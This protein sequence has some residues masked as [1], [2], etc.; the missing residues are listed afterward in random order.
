MTENIRSIALG[1]VWLACSTLRG[2]DLAETLSSIAAGGGAPE[3]VSKAL[4][5]WLDEAGFDRLREALDAT[6]EAKQRSAP[7]WLSVACVE[8]HLQRDKQALAAWKKACD[9]P[10][11]VTALMQLGLA[12]A[13]ARQRQFDEAG[14]ALE[15]MDAAKADAHSVKEA[16][17]L[18]HSMAYDR[19][20]RADQLTLPQRLAE[21]RPDDADL[22]LLLA[23]M[24]VERGS[25]PEAIR[26]T[27]EALSLAQEAPAKRAWLLVVI[28]SESR[29]GKYLEA[30]QDA[31]QGL[32]E[33]APNSED[34][35]Q[36]LERLTQALQQERRNPSKSVMPKEEEVAQQFKD[37]P[38]VVRRMAVSLRAAG[39]TPAAHEVLDLLKEE[40]VAK[41]L[42]SDWQE[43]DG[44]EPQPLVRATIAKMSKVEIAG[45]TAAAPAWQAEVKILDS[46]AR[47][48][49][50]LE[51]WKAD[52]RDQAAAL[53]L[54]EQFRMSSR[55]VEL[56]QVVLQTH[57][58][59]ADSTARQAWW[60]QPF[61]RRSANGYQGQQWWPS[62]RWRMGG[63]AAYWETLAVIHGSHSLAALREAVRLAPENERTK[64]DL[65]KSLWR[66]GS[67]EEALHLLDGMTTVQGRAA[68]R[69]E[70]AVIDLFHGRPHAATRTMFAMAG[71]EALDAD[72]AATLSRGL[73]AWREWADAVVFLA[74]QRQRFP[75]DYR[76]AA[77]QGLAL[78]SAGERIKAAEVFLEM[79]GFEREIAPTP[80]NDQPEEEGMRMNPRSS[81]RGDGLQEWLQVQQAVSTALNTDLGLVAWTTQQRYRQ[82][83][84]YR[85][86]L[87]PP[88][89]QN[90][91]A[92]GMAH[93]LVMLAKQPEAERQAWVEKARTAKLPMPELLVAGKIIQEQG[94][95]ARLTLDP[96]W[97]E[98]HLDL[99]WV[100]PL[101]LQTA[102]MQQPP[103]AV[104]AELAL[105]VSRVTME[106]DAHTSLR[107]ALL[108]WRIAPQNPA[109]PE[110]VA[111]VLARGRSEDADA[112][113]TEL[114]SGLPQVPLEVR[115]KAATQL[116]EA[117][118]SLS[119]KVTD[120]PRR[121]QMHLA[122]MQA[123]L[124][125][126][127]WE[128]AAQQAEAA[129]ASGS[130]H[131]T[132]GTAAATP[133]LKSVAES[134][135]SFPAAVLSW[136]VQRG[137]ALW[138]TLIMFQSARGETTLFTAEEKAAFLA[139][140]AKI[141]DWG[142][143]LQWHLTGD[144]EPGAK[145][146]V[147][148][149]LRAQPENRDAV[150]VAAGLAAAEQDLPHALDLL[151]A[152]MQAQTKP[153]E[154]LMAQIDYL[155]AGAFQGERPFRREGLQEALP[156]PP[157]AVHL[158]R[159]RKVAAE[160]L[161]R[162]QKNTQGYRAQWVAIYQSLGLQAEADTLKDKP[163]QQ[164]E[165]SMALWS[166][167]DRAY[168]A[169][170]ERTLR[171]REN[172]VSSNDIARHLN[173]K[174]GFQTA[175]ATELLVRCLR[176]EADRRFF[177]PRSRGDQSE[178]WPQLIRQNNLAKEVLA[179][180]EPGPAPTWRR[181]V[182]A[183]HAAEACEA[184]EQMAAWAAEALKQD[185]GNQT[186]QLALAGARLRSSGD[187]AAMVDALKALSPAEGY[188]SLE[189]LLKTAQK[190]ADFDQRLK[191]AGAVVRLA[192]QQPAIM[193]PTDESRGEAVADTFALLT[194]AVN[195]R[196]GRS[197]APA[198]YTELILP[199]APSSTSNAS[200]R[201]P[202]TSPATADQL[203]LRKKLFV[204][205]CELSLKHPEWLRETLRRLAA[206]HLV[207]GQPEAAVLVNYVKQGLTV[208]P[209]QK[210][211]YFNAFAG[212]GLVLK[213][214]EM[215]LRLA[216]LA[217]PLLGTVF[218]DP[219]SQI[220]TDSASNNL[221]QLIGAEIRAAKH[222]PLWALWECPLDA[223][224]GEYQH[225]PEQ[226]TLN[227]ERRELM[228]QLWQASEP[229]PQLR[230]QLFPFWAGYRL[231][232]VDKVDEVLAVARS[233][234]S[235]AP[236]DFS[237]LREFV[238]KA[239]QS[240]ENPHHILAA[241]LVEALLRDKLPNL[242]PEE[243]EKPVSQIIRIL[244]QGRT[245]QSDPM[246]PLSAAPEEAEKVLSR[247]MQARRRTVLSR[248][249]ELLGKDYATTP[250]LLFA[251]F[252]EA[253]R[254]D[255]KVTKIIQDIV[256]LA[257]R[258][259]QQVQKALLAF[260]QAGN[261]KPL[262][263]G[264]TTGY[265]G[266]AWELEL[267]LRWFTAT[268]E[269]GKLL[270]KADA[271]RGRSQYEWLQY[272]IMDLIQP[273]LL[274]ELPVPPPNGMEP[275]HDGVYG[276]TALQYAKNPLIKKRD[277]LLLTGVE[278]AMQQ[279]ELWLSTF[280]SYTELQM[281]R[282][283]PGTRQIMAVLDQHCASHPEQY[284]TALSQ[285]TDNRSFNSLE[286]RLAGASIMLKVLDAWPKNQVAGDF[287][288]SIGN[289]RHI[290]LGGNRSG[291]MQEIPLL[292]DMPWMEGYHSSQQDWEL[293]QPGAKERHAAWV[294]VVNKALTI[295]GMLAAVFKDVAQL[296][297]AKEP[298]KIIA[299]ARKLS[300]DDWRSV[301]SDLLQLF[302]NEERNAAV[303][304]RLQWGRLVLQLL[305]MATAL[306]K[307]APQE[308][309]KPTW[310]AATLKYLRQSPSNSTGAFRA[311][312]PTVEILAERETLI[313]QLGAMVLDDPGMAVEGLVNFAHQQFTAGATPEATLALARKSL[314]HDAAQL[315]R[316]LETWCSQ[317]LRESDATNAERAWCLQVLLPLAE[318]WPEENANWLDDVS[319]VLNS[320]ASSGMTTESVKPQAERLMNAA[321]R[322]PPNGTVLANYA[323]M[324]C[325]TQEGQQQLT[326]RLNR[327]LSQDRVQA[328]V[329][330]Q[331][332][333]RTRWGGAT[334][335]V[336]R[337]VLGLL[338]AW[339]VD[340]PAQELE[341]VEGF[342]KA[343]AGPARGRD[344]YYEG[345][346][347]GRAN[348]KPR[349]PPPAP[350]FDTDSRRLQQEALLEL[351]RRKVDQPWMLP[352]ELRLAGHSTLEAK[353][354]V[355]GLRAFF[356]EPLLAQT[357][358]YCTEV[359]GIDL[360]TEARRPNPDM[361]RPLMPGERMPPHGDAS[362]ILDVSR[363]L[364]TAAQQ[365]WL[366]EDVLKPLREKSFMQLPLLISMAARHSE[367]MRRMPPSPFASTGGVLESQG[368]EAQTLLNAWDAMTAKDKKSALT[369]EQLPRVL[370]ARLKAG[371]KPADLVV[372]VTDMMK[373]DPAATAMALTH[374]AYTLEDHHL[375][376][377]VFLETG[378]LAALLAERWTAAQPVPDWLVFVSRSWYHGA[379]AVPAPPQSGRTF[380]Q[381]FPPGA[382]PRGGPPPGFPAGSFPGTLPRSIPPEETAQYEKVAKEVVPHFA[383]ALRRF[384]GCTDDSYFRVMLTA[385]QSSG[386]L[387]SQEISSLALAHLQARPHSVSRI[388]L[389]GAYGTNPRRPTDPPSLQDAVTY[390][391]DQALQSG[392]HGELPPER[393]KIIR[394]ALKPEALGFY[395]ALETLATSTAA[396]FP[397]AAAALMLANPGSRTAD[398]AMWILRSAAQKK[399]HIPA[400]LWVE[401]TRMKENFNGGN[402]QDSQLPIALAWL[403]QRASET[404]S[405]PTQDA[406]DLLR[407]MLG[408]EY[409]REKMQA[410]LK[411]PA[412]RTWNDTWNGW[413]G[414]GG[415][416]SY[417]ECRWAYY[418]ME[419]MTA[420][421]ELFNT[422]LEL[423]HESGLA[424]HPGVLA[425]LMMGSRTRVWY[426]ED[427]ARWQDW[428]TKSTLLDDEAVPDARWLL[429]RD[430]LAPVWEFA[431]A[432]GLDTHFK[433]AASAW[434]QEQQT[435][436]PT[437]GR[438]LLLLA[439]QRGH[440]EDIPVA[441]IEAALVPCRAQLQKAST[442]RRAALTAALEALQP[443]LEAAVKAA[444]P[445][446]VLQLLPPATVPPELEALARRWM[447]GGGIPASDPAQEVQQRLQPLTAMIL[448]LLQSGVKESPAVMVAG[449]KAL[450][451]EKW[452]LPNTAPRMSNEVWV[453]EHL[454]QE[455]L[456]ATG[457]SYGSHSN[458]RV[459]IITE[460]NDDSRRHL[461]LQTIR[462]LLQNSQKF[463]SSL[464]SSSWGSIAYSLFPVKG[465]TAMS[466]AQLSALLMG[467]LPAKDHGEALLALKLLNV[468]FPVSN[469]P[470]LP[471]LEQLAAVS[472]ARQPGS[473]LA[474]A[475]H[476]VLQWRKATLTGG[477]APALTPPAA[478]WNDDSTS[479]AA[480]LDAIQQSKAPPPAALRVRALQ[481]WALQ[482]LLNIRDSLES[483]ILNHPLS[484]LNE[485]DV[486]AP[487]GTAADDAAAAL[488]LWLR[489]EKTYRLGLSA[490]G[491]TG[492]GQ[493]VIRP[494]L[495]ALQR[496][497][498]QERRAELM[499]AAAAKSRL[500]LEPLLEEWRAA[501]DVPQ[502]VRDWLPRYFHER[503]DEPQ[504]L[505]EYAAKDLPQLTR[506]DET[507]LASLSHAE[508]DSLSKLTASL[509]LAA[510]PDA[511][512][513]APSV[514]RVERVK[515]RLAL[516]DPS[517]PNELTALNRFLRL[518][519]CAESLLPE[520]LP[521]LRQHPII[522]EW[523]S[524]MR[525]PVEMPRSTET[526]LDSRRR[527]RT[528]TLWAAAEALHAGNRQPWTQWTAT[529]AKARA[530]ADAAETTDEY[531]TRF[532]LPPGFKLPRV[533]EELPCQTAGHIIN[534]YLA[535]QAVPP[536]V[537][538]SLW[539]ELR[540]AST[541]F[542]S[543]DAG[544]A[545][546]VRLALAAGLPAGNEAA[547]KRLSGLK[548]TLQTLPRVLE[549][550][551]LC[552]LNPAEKWRVLNEIALNRMVRSTLL[553]TAIKTGFVTPAELGVM[554]GQLRPADC[555]DW[556]AAATD[557]LDATDA[558]NECTA[559][560]RKLATLDSTKLPPLTWHLMLQ[561]AT[562]H[563]APDL[564]M[565][566]QTHWEKAVAAASK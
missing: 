116:I 209:Q 360:A 403:R 417:Q 314:K 108:A 180:V 252:E 266:G 240:Y 169:H 210:L 195:D 325:T 82:V 170:L 90:A 261:G 472:A 130:A 182:Q 147:S 506:Q 64:V 520:L 105:K 127:A 207:D 189:E 244:T 383:D 522:H 190:T 319:F 426:Q 525:L 62:L 145:Q 402:N 329:W 380:P 42:I 436:Q 388:L 278:L 441:A 526:D 222:P 204:E 366:G 175:P 484:W 432:C 406:R 556:A 201:Q 5:P 379:W 437:V 498:K 552:G 300:F 231:H 33:T 21:Q 338:K 193:S 511:T 223:T 340:A 126:G 65:A 390:L 307:Y 29:Q 490:G 399:A 497:G 349:V 435:R 303:E 235:D 299:A 481:A 200:T 38:A 268:L 451:A 233:L 286:A 51:V 270:M 468:Q 164:A 521:L 389:P 384:P 148:A 83:G 74:A 141:Q 317:G 39:A 442:A 106:A 306:E 224:T 211:S 265:S 23:Q 155:L 445:Q 296:N 185:A 538:L 539:D 524:G 347:P 531:A 176:G 419:S 462:F 57:F 166:G 505:W 144:D 461:K 477:T 48:K 509:V 20:Q 103:K 1:F 375:P 100:G 158:K 259:P 52:P 79:G 285:W 352:L 236:N 321:M 301:Q 397:K 536:A 350:S 109:A 287:R 343:L 253:L 262:S 416:M 496:A 191:L 450:A 476:N 371:E 276:S 440:N 272:W 84:D 89:V 513:E 60:R 376:L 562:A 137:S 46:E 489:Q 77:L 202:S 254:K 24:A 331:A 324:T 138:S 282:T 76:L 274:A 26:R 81:V 327:L 529:I 293:K 18:L 13:L 25:S 508:D 199:K 98:K 139:A 275:G 264:Q 271:G 353:T 239:V 151:H 385:T 71:D 161:P 188:R 475:S 284:F 546:G 86:Q 342:I 172:P 257:Q 183:V 121:Y 146:V 75:T 186:L 221:A 328:A 548:C 427:E 30:A 344:P 217:L 322:L 499:Q 479:N 143:K 470:S 480:L 543:D 356:A 220:N 313:Q 225:T 537:L 247:D 410:A 277:E 463:T 249:T 298:E 288:Q 320:M 219:K 400:A 533:W 179:A 348:Q 439:C 54:I 454:G 373:Q 346:N 58:S 339:P 63:S 27:K 333:W 47:L 73:I 332:W 401:I 555:A 523:Q 430:G 318:E 292:P 409:S 22:K 197:V 251:Q 471:V 486:D 503:M 120:D 66:N 447:A 334:V 393:G 507:W 514:P 414:G 8:E 341:W 230:R 518:P 96:A 473:T 11:N 2:Q 184:W 394:A 133:S 452:D 12:H 107:A 123:A 232:F 449:V 446:S 159:L 396:D 124:C 374:W 269:L 443:D 44:R 203:E 129:V 32:A 258:Q 386:G 404:K 357:L 553:A 294:R 487:L 558:R 415:A 241:E 229:L 330:M 34:E 492:L 80:D 459:T 431:K 112:L 132:G 391:L 163:G 70:T 295:P 95:S 289:W 434:L 53:Q 177:S 14:K 37:R 544:I 547:R 228:D 305:P 216:R 326:A 364:L 423:A 9:S 542:Q 115:R 279:D 469:P 310:V 181:L 267:R 94:Q 387:P 142:V 245:N 368:I 420:A 361:G 206:R 467:M 545:L 453:Q 549:T 550:A 351:R 140:G 516:L 31:L 10:Q 85:T 50:L 395:D 530:A 214:G 208:Q 485:V 464:L 243:A 171:D 168:L 110:A 323:R 392:E 564:V 359:T 411:Q 104:E 358:A 6:Q 474:W 283:P 15:E 234:A 297:V 510:L 56:L 483:R 304:R 97:I 260:I 458:G 280:R 311:P 250:E 93:L 363:C 213:D 557:W 337:P 438:A 428:L 92:W 540:A 131:Q 111:A 413:P 456:D 493:R 466:G 273:N 226:L 281:A 114:A 242:K 378:R 7:D 535:Q 381:G 61:L 125:L 72:L 491:E 40:A 433:T 308:S 421:P 412:S 560:I 69:L 255:Q 377:P 263:R 457:D 135:L 527:A 28:D 512:A 515:Q 99:S 372:L 309:S 122:L 174:Q 238:E 35:W 554:I 152:R 49:K 362:E 528:I 192:A 367:G 16:V 19:G 4:V 91:A 194:E 405:D 290:M 424:Q 173:A 336:S 316:H 88:T 534:H 482:P 227:K 150:L 561:H 291:K 128:T 455:L 237:L 517:K 113:I 488:T 118:N 17:W 315:G 502:A 551:K 382:F 136:P 566:L 59:C 563:E 407:V 504:T 501:A 3:V 425:W 117:S 422:N 215:R 494:L 149:W 101:W 448:R 162:L 460:S 160:L 165:R 248:L 345:W 532:R 55:P 212:M 119:Q 45:K 519:G 78:Q 87:T 196:E 246:P 36:L 398:C 67:V 541:D 154:R 102:P 157:P 41:K 369:A 365:A 167:E 198:L 187:P 218:D 302:G 134:R 465:K 495:A 408:K 178:P 354:R 43:E 153:E 444:P 565:V 478:F 312:P 335:Q 355:E 156:E 500:S 559:F 256:K 205:F 418:F 429:P 68:A 370:E